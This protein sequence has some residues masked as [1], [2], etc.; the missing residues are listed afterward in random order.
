VAEVAEYMIADQELTEFIEDFKERHP[1]AL[2]A[3]EQLAERRNAVLEAAKKAVKARQM[4][5]GPFEV[6]NVSTIYDADVLFNA[7]GE[8]LFKTYGGSVE[9][10]TELKIDGKRFEAAVTFRKL[11]PE[12]VE[13]VRKTR[14][15]FKD[16][17][18]TWVP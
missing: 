17:P 13:A 18:K 11:T 6:H 7:V 16:I 5:C 2:E 8:E 12:L 9:T 10:K 14:V 1:G 15:A 3:L 4:P